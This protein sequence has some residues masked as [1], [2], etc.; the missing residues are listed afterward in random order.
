MAEARLGVDFGRVINYAAGPP[1]GDDTVFLRGG[2]AEAMRTPPMPGMFDV[3]PRLVA[4]FGGRVWL[5]SKCG[6]QTQRRT[7]QW[8]DHHDFWAR[9][10]IPPDHARFCRKRAEKAPH[11][12]A[13]GITHFI[14]D[15]I[16]IHEVLRGLVPHLYLFGEQKAS[17]PPWL[18]HT[19]T[20]ADVE[21]AILTEDGAIRR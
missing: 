19:L 14:D 1:D 8:L 21:R 16:E 6:E 12:V 18:T 2:F 4:A 9:T 13:L 7:E 10:G 3:L 17:P 20:W 5:V 15:R 11:C